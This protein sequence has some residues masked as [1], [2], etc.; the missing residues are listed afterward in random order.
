MRREN[1]Q[2]AT[3]CIIN[4]TTFLDDICYC[5]FQ[6]FCVAAHKKSQKRGYKSGVS[7]NDRMRKMNEK[8]Y[9]EQRERRREKERERGEIR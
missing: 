3:I 4:L 8:G 9:R 1:K 2:N 6:L 7:G 5:Y